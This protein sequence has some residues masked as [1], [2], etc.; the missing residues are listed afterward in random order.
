MYIEDFKEI[1]SS[2]Q[3][4]DMEREFQESLKE[5]NLLSKS[6][7]LYAFKMAFQNGCVGF[8]V[9]PAYVIAQKDLERFFNTMFGVSQTEK[10][11]YAKQC[12]HNQLAIYIDP[13]KVVDK[14]ADAEKYAY[15]GQF[16][17]FCFDVIL[18]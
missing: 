17:L 18:P 4:R 16:V 12:S 1:L 10:F 14:V 11:F 15:N 7:I 5:K 13:R 2:F 9:C 3:K 6:G 8:H